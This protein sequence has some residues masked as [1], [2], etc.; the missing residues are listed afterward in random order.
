VT[1]KSARTA[2]SAATQFP[3]TRLE[4]S[5]KAA[6]ASRAPWVA[7]FFALSSSLWAIIG[8]PQLNC[9]YPLN[10]VVVKSGKA[11]ERRKRH[12]KPIYK[13]KRFASAASTSSFL[14]VSLSK[15]PRHGFLG[16]KAAVLSVEAFP[17]KAND[18][19]AK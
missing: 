11:N 9:S 5:R 4:R 6:D 15:M 17:I 19:T 14:L 10:R 18:Y 1:K 7:D 13:D 8:T 3:I 12:S 16:L 2:L